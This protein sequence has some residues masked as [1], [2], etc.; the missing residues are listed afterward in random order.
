MTAPTPYLHFHG[1]AR[2]VLTFYG[3]CEGMMLSLL[4]T[5]APATLRAWFS[6]LSELNPDLGLTPTRHRRRRSSP[7]TVDQPPE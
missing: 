3:R 4:G 7:T 5:A 2:D 1:D 6:S